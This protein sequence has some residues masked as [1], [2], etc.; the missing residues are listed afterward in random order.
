LALDTSISTRASLSLI[1]KAAANFTDQLRPLDRIA[2]YEIN[3]IV[4]QIQGFTSDRKRLK[5]AIESIATSSTGGSKIYDGVAQA[6][7]EL[8][9]ARTGRQAV[10]LLSDGMENSSRTRF[11]DLRRLLAQSNVV[12]YPVTILNKM[13]QKDLLDDF[14]K[15][16]DRKDPNAG[17]YVENAKKSLSFLE[18]IYQIQTERL[19]TFTEETGGKIFLVGALADLA[20]EYAKVAQELRNTFSLAYYSKNKDRDGSMRRIEVKVKNPNYLVRSRSS[21]LVPEE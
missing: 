12:F 7:K 17:I 19:H 1:K 20:E 13:S 5:R 3:F 21:Y 11:E 18:E 4:R 8:Q 10:I 2:I 14:I 16:A 9:K 15:N 6:V